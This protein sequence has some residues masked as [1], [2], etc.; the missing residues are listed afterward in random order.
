MMEMRPCGHVVAAHNVLQC[1]SDD[2]AS[3]ICGLSSIVAR[4]L[5]SL[6]MYLRGTKM[7]WSRN[8]AMVSGLASSVL[9]FIITP[10]AS[11]T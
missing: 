7:S 4:N 10:T 6:S 2:G 3:C 9:E 1:S 5:D 8:I 11:M